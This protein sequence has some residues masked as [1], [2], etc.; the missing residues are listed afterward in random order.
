MMVS[1]VDG[2]MEGYTN[3]EYDVA[4]EA[5]ASLALLGNP[6]LQDYINIVRAGL[7]RNLPVTPDSVTNSNK[8]FDPEVYSL[9]VK[10]VQ[11][12]QKQS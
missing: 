12:H 7:V 10:T 9:K 8:I 6:I 11:N 4:K 2:N 5:R 3:R 1:T